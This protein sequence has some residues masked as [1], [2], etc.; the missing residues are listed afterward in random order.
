MCIVFFAHSYGR[1]KLVIAGNRDEFL[2]RPT[3]RAHRDGDIFGGTDIAFAS[4]Y[5]SQLFATSNNKSKEIENNGSHTDTASTAGTE[6][7]RWMAIN[8]RSGKFSFL[9]NYRENTPRLDAQSRGCLVR[10]YLKGEATPSRYCLQVDYCKS[11]WNGFHLIAGDLESISYVG[12]SGYLHQLNL[13]QVHGI[14]NGPFLPS[15]SGQSEWPKVSHGKMIFKEIMDND[16]GIKELQKQLF[17]LL[18]NETA[19]PASDIPLGLDAEMERKLS[20]ICIDKDRFNGAYATRTM[21][22]IIVDAD[23]HGYFIERDLYSGSERSIHTT[24]EEFTID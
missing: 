9:T 16:L 22:L 19:Y 1:Y 14:S 11:D 18:A 4:G 6:N 3:A 23:N 12:S 21:T 24:V 5:K 20:T 8:T 2:D 15:D 17:A 13:E 10:D 7:G